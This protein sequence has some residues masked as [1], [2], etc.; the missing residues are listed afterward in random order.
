MVNTRNVSRYTGALPKGAADLK[1]RGGPLY[2]AHK[3]SDLLSNGG[4]QAI[5][6][7]TK[8]CVSDIQKWNMN[9]DD[10]LDLVGLAVRSGRFIGAEWC[11]QEP[12]GPCAACDGY[13]VIRREWL[14][15]AHK[16]MDMEYYMKFAIGK[17]GTILLLASC[18]P[19][20]F[21]G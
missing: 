21:R 10:V 5:M 8:K 16:E 13:S 20:E 19:S 15:A 6:A 14:A 17:T 18:H 7:W 9:E 1:I 3:I 11:E 2:P 4:S 12:N